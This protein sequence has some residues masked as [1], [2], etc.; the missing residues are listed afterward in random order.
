MAYV[1][2]ECRFFV[3]CTEVLP[4]MTQWLTRATGNSFD[5]ENPLYRSAAHYLARIR[6]WSREQWD[7][8]MLHTLPALL[9]RFHERRSLVASSHLLANGAIGLILAVCEFATAL[10]DDAVAF[11]DL[12]RLWIGWAV[13]CVVVWLNDT[14]WLTNAP[15][16][17]LSSQTVLT[18]DMI[19]AAMREAEDVRARARRERLDEHALDPV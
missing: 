9:N 1:H 10:D 11:R 17:I 14:F 12:V 6:F 18:R 2:R 16:S 13:D 7:L 4:E 15:P 3:G 19:D 8:I 5:V